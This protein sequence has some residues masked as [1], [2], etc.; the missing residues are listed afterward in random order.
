[1]IQLT[2]SCPPSCVVCSEDITLCQGLTYILAV[3]ASTK[4]LIVT[5]GSITSVE[6]FNLSF[7]FNA[8]LLRLSANG[9]TTI[10]DDAF[11][12][13]RTLKTLLLDQ[14]QISSSSI[15]YS[16]FH[17]LQKLQVL[18]LSNNILSRIRGIWFMSTKDLIRLHLNG[19]QLMSITGESFEMAK[20]GKLRILDLSNNFISSIEKRAFHGLA[21]LMEIDLSRNRLAIIPDT[22]SSLAQLSLLSLDQNSWNCT[23][24]LHDLASFLRKYV[25]SSSRMLR[26]A[27]NVSCRAS[28]NPSVTNLLELTEVNCKS[29]LKHPPG[30]L[31]N[32]RRNY[33]RDVALVAVFSFLGGVGLTCLVLALFNRKFQHGKANEH[34]SGNCCCRTL[35]ESQCGHEPRNYLTK[36]YCNCHLTRENEIKVMSMLGSGRET[37][38]LKENSHQATVKAES[39]CTGLKM[40]LR[41]IQKENE[42]MKNDHFLC[43]NCR[44]LQS[45]PPESSGNAAVPNEADGLCQK[46]FQR[47]VRMGH[48]RIKSE[49]RIA[50]VNPGLSLENRDT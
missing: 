39:K 3:P 8:T 28:E 41:S 46:Q 1:M 42:Q 7:L 44:L 21:Q 19:N 26:N 38:L 18:V 37:P 32:R 25:N 50:S 29:A 14:N 40:P 30:I 24:K 10:R 9:I 48:S 47:R 49:T 4:A 45:Y 12:G 34:S 6:G 23:C 15:T 36:G 13:L 2:A 17:E 35:D 20:L 11:L 16:T 22:F 27:D 31:E 5:D 43:L 33:G